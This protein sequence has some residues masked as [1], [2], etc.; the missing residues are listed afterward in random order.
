MGVKIRP[1]PRVNQDFINKHLICSKCKKPMK[2]DD[3]DT[4]KGV[5]TYW[6]VCPCKKEG[7]VINTNQ[8]GHI[9][10]PV[11]ITGGEGEVI[12]TITKDEVLNENN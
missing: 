11:V 9:I 1:R 7:S 12:K 4:W 3:K 2:L 8:N 10:F 6:F 5:T